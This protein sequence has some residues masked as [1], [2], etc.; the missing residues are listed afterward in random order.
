[1]PDHVAGVAVVV[2]R[3]LLELVEQGPEVAEEAP[4]DV[5]DLRPRRHADCAAEQV[6]RLIVAPE[7]TQGRAEVVA[8]DEPK[9]R[10]VQRERDRLAEV[11]LRR[12]QIGDGA[13]AVE[14][15]PDKAMAD[16]LGLSVSALLRQSK[17]LAIGRERFAIALGEVGPLALGE[18][19]LD[20]RRW[21]CHGTG[22]RYHD[23]GDSRSGECVRNPPPR[24]STG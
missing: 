20:A 21:C 2:A 19:R 1:M 7:V 24:A 5:L 8:H 10:V 9:A 13:E 4:S 3:S 12:G 17:R 15:Q 14:R 6:V 18:E 16:R 22:E 11:G 23:P